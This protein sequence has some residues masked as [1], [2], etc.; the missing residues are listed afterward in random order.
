MNL[1]EK[2][3]AI[4]LS[5]VGIREHGTNAGPEVE[6]WQRS[7]K[8]PKG[9]P[10]CAAYVN[11]CAEE[12]ADAL[13]VV[14]P[15]ES[16]PLQGY[17]Q[18]YYEHFAALGCIVAPADALPG[19]LFVIWYLGLKRYGHIGFVG[20]DGVSVRLGRYATVEGNTNAAGSREGDRVAAK[21][22]VLGRHVRFIRWT[23]VVQMRRK[24][25]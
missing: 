9:S 15:L 2:T 25:A 12:G 10:W 6:A 7:A 21:R 24:A 17:V 11:D 5:R 14:S 22:R 4:A 3:L 23:R 1:R 8:I 13:G 16:V 20:P 18:S 19:D